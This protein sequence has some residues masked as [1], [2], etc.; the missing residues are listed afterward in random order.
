[1]MMMTATS[2]VSII[3]TAAELESLHP[4]SFPSF[5]LSLSLWLVVVKHQSQV[6]PF[7]CIS[8]AVAVAVQCG[9][10]ERIVRT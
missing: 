4:S 7:V 5:S 1:M 8:G 3:P 2:T 10:I 9:G 6:R